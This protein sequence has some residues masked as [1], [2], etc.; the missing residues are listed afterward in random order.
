MTA[1]KLTILQK[2][3]FFKRPLALKISSTINLP[4]SDYMLNDEK[5]RCNFIKQNDLL[6][7]IIYLF[8]YIM[9][10]RIEMK[11]VFLV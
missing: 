2:P 6:C 10:V 4:E 7:Y 3:I 8:Y 11:W 9:H 5:N 1:L